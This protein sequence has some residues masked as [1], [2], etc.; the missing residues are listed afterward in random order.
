MFQQEW[1]KTVQMIEETQ[2]NVDQMKEKVGGPQQPRTIDSKSSQS[3][4]LEDPPKSYRSGQQSLV[5]QGL[6]NLMA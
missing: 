6:S 1:D 5:S 3:V 2:K 4:L